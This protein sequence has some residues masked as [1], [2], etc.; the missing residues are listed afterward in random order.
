MINMYE[1]KIPAGVDVTFSDSTLTIKGKLGSTSKTINTRL[2]SIGIDKEK[3]TIGLTS[4]KRFAKKAALAAKAL[5]TELSGAI[6]GV[7]NGIERK[8]VVFYAHFPT[9][10]EIKGDKI[11]IK[12]IFGEKVP[13]ITS[14]VGSTKVEVKGQDV[15]VKGVDPYD[16]GQTIAN[17]R[18]ICFARG[19]DT[20]VFQ[21]GIYLAKEE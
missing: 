17:I 20:R 9:T 18:G 15:T 16:V 11:L 5:D 10:I 13:R 21:D 1:I 14:I 19:N 8:M 4:N 6:A 2:V 3:M 7:E 12:N